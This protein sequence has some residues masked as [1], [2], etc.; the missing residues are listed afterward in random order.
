MDCFDSYIECVYYAAS[1]D[2]SDCEFSD[3][4][5]QWCYF[6]VENIAWWVWLLISIGIVSV[7]SSIACC[8]CCC[9]KKKVK[10]QKIVEVNVP[11]MEQQIP[12][13]YVHPQPVYQSVQNVPQFNAPYQPASF[14]QVPT[15]PQMK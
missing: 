10:Y 4:L 12:V 6:S 14:Y 1:K 11:S 5:Y 15:L 7:I 2:G 3:G 13:Q 9:C 8:I